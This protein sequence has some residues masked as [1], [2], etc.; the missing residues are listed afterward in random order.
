M[1]NFSEK[2]FEYFDY[3]CEHKRNV[4]KAYNVLMKNNPFD[5]V[6]KPMID[7]VL[8]NRVLNHDLSKFSPEQFKPYRKH[9]YPNNKDE[10]ES[11][12]FEEA[13][14]YHYNNERH[15]PERYNGEENMR[16]LDVLEMCLDWYAMSLKFG[17]NTLEYY[18]NKKDELRKEHPWLIEEYDGL[19]TKVLESMCDE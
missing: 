10:E 8:K 16:S 2:D 1:I 19:I 11:N 15:H 6:E 4:M 12:G 3:I 17:D 7:K 9:F 14:K 13:W 18:N 5:E